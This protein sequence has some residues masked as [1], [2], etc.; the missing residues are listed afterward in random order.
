MSKGCMIF[1]FFLLCT[2]A[3]AYDQKR[4]EEGEELFRRCIPCHGQYGNKQPMG[5]RDIS[6][7]P[8]K[9]IS[10]ILR[11]YALGKSEGAM[12]AQAS[13]L[14]QQKIAAL[15]TYI[16]S[17]KIKQGSEVFALRCS[18]CHGKDASKSAFGK[19]GKVSNLTEPELIRVLRNY[20][21]GVYAHGST[22]NAMKGRAIS[23]NDNEIDA[24]AR[25]VDTL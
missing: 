20:Q 6:R 12:N 21:S 9:D 11:D 3:F 16:A 14:D 2:C 7:L 5:K 4:F 19:S 10:N 8:E 22:A 15:A 25:F 24:L 18:G 13:L 1:A 17:M 23:L